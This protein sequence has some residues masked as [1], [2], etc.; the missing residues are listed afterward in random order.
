MMKINNPYKMKQKVR[1]NSKNRK[2]RKRVK[3]LIKI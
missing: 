2:E 3:N 1:V